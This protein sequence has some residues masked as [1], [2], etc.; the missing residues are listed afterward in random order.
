M[1]NGLQVL[2]D[3]LVVIHHH[4]EM[5]RTRARIISEHLAV[6]F[7]SMGVPAYLRRR[8]RIGIHR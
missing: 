8:S 7:R 2:F 6:G 3:P 4:E 1:V 5:L